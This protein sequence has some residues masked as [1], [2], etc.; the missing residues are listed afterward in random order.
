MVGWDDAEV[1][2][3]P[4]LVVAVAVLTAGCQ[5]AG[6]DSTA[7]AAGG[8]SLQSIGS[9]T[10]PVWVGTPTKDRRIFI[11]EKGGRIK[12]RNQ[13]TPFLDI[14][15]RVST[16]GEQGLLS[17][18]FANDWS[19]THR[20]YVYYT[21]VNGTIRVD[22]YSGSPYAAN[23]A[24]RREVL[25][26]PHP[27]Q[28][29]HNG[30]LLVMRTDN[31]MLIGLGDGGGAGDP[32]QNSQSL[33]TFLG[34]ILRID[35][36]RSGTKRYTVP[37]NN[38]FVHTTGAR[39]E[40]WISGVRNPWR[41]SID[42]ANQDLWV[43]DVGQGNREEADRIPT[44]RQ[45]GANLGWSR[46]EGNTTYDANH[47]LVHAGT[48]LV[49]P[50]FA[51]GHADGSCSITGGVVYRGKA[52]PGIVGQYLFADL[53][54]PALRAYNPST[55]SFFSPIADAGAQ[56]VSIGRDA[57]GEVLLANLG[58]SVTKLVAG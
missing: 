54:K 42:P 43:G 37:T 5:A 58:G 56:V 4:A 20:F 57:D 34:K 14:T 9:A 8:Y 53:C 31:T 44:A 24:T 21:D 33:A 15:S 46:Y 12:I 29:N 2:V 25:S 28:T 52:L 26:Q 51:Y 10:Q 17:M 40:I 3:G 50:T 16:G 18:A 39:P 6:V 48:F 55:K 11:V 23:P 32:N 19:T 35:P 36:R 38:P 41:Y 1:R 27:G 13:A 45:A 7:P 47:R 22:E 49:G 30:G